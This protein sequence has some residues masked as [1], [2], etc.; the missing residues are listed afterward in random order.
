MDVP[1]YRELKVWQKAHK[2]ALDI[3]EL[4]KDVPNQP[5]LNRIVDQIVGSASSVGANIAEGSSSRRGKEYIR[6]LEIALRSATECDNW[7][8]VV[9]DSQ[10]IKKFVDL[11]KLQEIEFMNIEVLKM[12]IKM[13]E[14][15]E[16]KREEEGL[17]STIREIV[18]DYLP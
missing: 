2:V 9:K 3:I 17:G 15:L 10:E 1:K 11:H 5:G 12:L 8:Q 14:S 6:Y 13:I 18:E 7:I 4:L 16:K